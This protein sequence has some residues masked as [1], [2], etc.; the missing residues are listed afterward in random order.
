M[1]SWDETDVLS[2]LEVIPEQECDGV[3]HKYTVEEDG[4]KLSLLI[5]PN[6]TVMFILSWSTLLI[7]LLSPA[8]LIDC[9]AV[10]R[11]VDSTGEYLEFAPS[12]CFGGR[13]DSNTSIPFWCEGF[14]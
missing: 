2:V 4:I 10:N 5:F 7:K 1:L 11:R 13:Y 9:E 8:K 6:M 3:W 14:C 12:K